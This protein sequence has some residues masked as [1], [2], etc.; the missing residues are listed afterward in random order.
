MAD[1]AA[2]PPKK[3]GWRRII[4][5]L[6]NR[7]TGYMAIFGFAAGLPYALLLGTLYAWLSDAEV[8]LE[9]MGVF[10]LNRA[11]VVSAILLYLTMRYLVN[12]VLVWLILMPV[13]RMQIPLRCVMTY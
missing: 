12:S 8:D 1:A 9:T 11:K 3:P 13:A 10:S 6:G 7:K 4:L 5:A 2:E